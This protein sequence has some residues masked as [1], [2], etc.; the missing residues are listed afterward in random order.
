MNDESLQFRLGAHCEV[1][2]G[3]CLSRNFLQQIELK[4]Y[5]H[6]TLKQ[7]QKIRGARMPELSDSFVLQRPNFLAFLF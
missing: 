3:Q 6:F 5:R 7:T 1:A 4:F 2:I